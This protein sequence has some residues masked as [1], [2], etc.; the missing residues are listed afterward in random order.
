MKQSRTMSFVESMLNI[1][2]GLGVAM[3]ANAIILPLVGFDVTLQQNAIIAVFMTVVSLIR[4]YGLRRL[5][6]AL[7]IRRPLSPFVQAVI[8]ERDRQIE[9][10]GWSLEHDDV[11]CRGE[12]ARAGASYVCCAA[13]SLLDFK[14]SWLAALWPW[15]SEDRKPQ[16]FRRDLVKG[17]ALIVA[18]GEKFDR[19]RKTK[20]RPSPSMTD[21]REVVRS[22]VVTA[23]RE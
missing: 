5:F 13:F 14:P 3:L 12:L 20:E 1:I 8:A 21:D 17:C 11:H 22:P 2:V 18:E 6:E 7:H 16:G 19:A 23:N 9:Q 15:R 10:E 4:S